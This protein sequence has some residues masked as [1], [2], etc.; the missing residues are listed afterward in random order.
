MSWW[1]VNGGFKVDKMKQYSHHDHTERQYK[2][3]DGNHDLSFQQ[4]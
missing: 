1:K 3:Q 4:A 2:Q